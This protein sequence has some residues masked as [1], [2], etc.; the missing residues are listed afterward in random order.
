MYSKN[1]FSNDKINLN[2]YSEHDSQFKWENIEEKEIQKAIF[3][4]NSKKACESDIFIFIYLFIK[5]MQPKVMAT[6]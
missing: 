5:C 1:S 3:T 6:I 2:D 4:S